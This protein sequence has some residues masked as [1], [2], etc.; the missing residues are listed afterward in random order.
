MYLEGGDQYRGWFHCSLLIGVAL[1][2]RGA[3]S[4][5]RDQRLD[6]G[7]RGPRDVK[8]ARDAIEPEKI[9]KKYGA[10]L[11]RLWTASVD[12]TE[13][14]RLSDTILDRLIEAYRKLRNTFR[15]RWAICTISIRRATPC[16]LEEMLDIDRW[17]LVARPKT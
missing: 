7:R 12:F 5:L 1:E 9:I 11:L 10:E 17:I 14:V 2:G 15:I 3:V 16:R 6:A 8:I 4:R 13:D